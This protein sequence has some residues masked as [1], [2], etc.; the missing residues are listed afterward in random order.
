MSHE[1]WFKRLRKACDELSVKCKRECLGIGYC[2]KCFDV[3]RVTAKR[4]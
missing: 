2:Q 3:A 4:K 1:A